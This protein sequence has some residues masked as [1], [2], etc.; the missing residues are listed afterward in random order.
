MSTVISNL[1]PQHQFFKLCEESTSKQLQ[2]NVKK[3][4]EKKV[5]YD[6][7]LNP[8]LSKEYQIFSLL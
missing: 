8:K 6:L 4:K 5:K 3:L 7:K 2:E 1:S